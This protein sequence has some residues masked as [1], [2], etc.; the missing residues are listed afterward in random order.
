MFSFIDQGLMFPIYLVG[1][2]VSGFMAHMDPEQL[3]T[4][5]RDEYGVFFQGEQLEQ[6]MRMANVLREHGVALMAVFALRTLA[7]FIGTLRMWQ[8]RGDGLHIYIT[9]QL[10]GILV[11][12]IVGGP[13]MFSFFGLL[14]SVTWCYF[15]WTQ[16][17]ALVD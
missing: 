8:L 7:R 15:Y 11:P 2:A 16:R 17:K 14:M 13:P 9:S 5:L 1:M 3:D 4:L 12:M 10:L 6:M